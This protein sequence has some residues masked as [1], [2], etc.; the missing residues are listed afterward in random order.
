MMKPL[1]T[2]FLALAATAT[3]FAQPVQSRTMD[4][5]TAPLGPSIEGIL[6]S[7]KPLLQESGRKITQ[8]QEWSRN[9]FGKLL[10]VRLT[11]VAQSPVPAQW[12]Y[13]DVLVNAFGDVWSQ[14][15]QVIRFQKLADKK[16]LDVEIIQTLNIGKV[17]GLRLYF[18][19]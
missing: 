15:W 7:Y 4:I 3:S 10:G 6:Q 17:T 14:A 18:G 2:L 11:H 16:L 5:T 8:I 1:I 13:Q 9:G 12:Q 19:D